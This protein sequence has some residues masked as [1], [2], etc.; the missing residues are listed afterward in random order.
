MV[1]RWKSG[2]PIDLFPTADNPDAGGDPQKNDNFDFAFTNP[3]DA[4]TQTRCP[5]AAHIRKTYP[6]NDLEGPP[7]NLDIDNRRIIR[8]GI[9]FGPEVTDDERKR[10]KTEHGRGLLFVCYQ[11]NIE[12]GFQFIQKS[13][14]P[15]DLA[16]NVVIR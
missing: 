11:S 5:F 8:A 6:R 7:F 3:D 9:P 12:D 15:L 2:A 14:F 4:T 10:G 1:G 16:L 13:S